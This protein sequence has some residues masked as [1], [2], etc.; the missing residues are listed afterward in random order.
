M[1]LGNERVAIVGSSGSGKSTLLALL[2]NLYPP[3]GGRVTLDGVD[4]ASLDG[5][6]LRGECLA[7]VPQEPVLLGGT[8]RDNVALGRPGASDAELRDAAARAGC[9]FALVDGAWE[10]EVGEQGVQLSGGQRQRIAIARVLLRPSPVVVLDEFTASLDA[11]TEAALL[12]SLADALAGR[13]LILITHRQAALRIADRVVE[14]GEG[15]RV[16][17]DSAAGPA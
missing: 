14:L 13:T 9:D 15:G 16:V 8:L 11:E 3:I 17:S 2:A 7:T 5:A 4:V 6:F 10:R 1:C 12:D